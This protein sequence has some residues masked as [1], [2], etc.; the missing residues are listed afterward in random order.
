MNPISQTSMSQPTLIPVILAGGKGERF[1]PL[2]RRARPKQ[3]LCLDGGDR[4][5]LQSTADRLVAT[6]G[7]WENLWVVTAAHLAEGMRE[8][9]PELPA[10]NLLVEPEGRDTAPAVAWS[11]I[12]VAKRYG[13]D[14]VIGFF[15]ADHWIADMDVFE[16]TL[17]AAATMAAK[18]DVVVT[19]GIAPVYASTGY[20]YI[21]QGAPLGEYGAGYAAYQVSRFT[22]KPDRDT[23]ESFVASGRF[24]WNGGMFVFKAA[25]VLAE[26]ALHAPEILLPL[27]AS[28]VAAY[29]EV[30]KMSIDYALMEK[31]TKAVVMPVKFGWD[32]LG[33]WGA[34]ER[35]NQS[36]APNVELAQHVGLETQGSLLYSTSADDLIVTI[37]L[38]DTVIVRD[39]NVTLVVKKDRTQDIKQVLKQ[40][41]S[42]PQYQ[43]LL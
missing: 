26:L 25:T 13:D 19:L 17:A 42:M 6:A 18:E 29:S 33:D 8:Q 40:L 31:T 35:L 32:D 7:G 23:A 2:S 11:T 9:L 28:G 37:G 14:V 41:Q 22:E 39:G 36:D 20:G 10:A 16:G 38:E 21:E 43:D 27:Q 5:L 24:S 15:P 1:W 4:S 34:I 30:T 12:E 3:F